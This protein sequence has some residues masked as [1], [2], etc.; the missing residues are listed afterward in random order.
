MKTE[1]R[2]WMYEQMLRVEIQVEGKQQEQ[3]FGGRG[4]H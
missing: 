2:V 3:K 4:T 1:K